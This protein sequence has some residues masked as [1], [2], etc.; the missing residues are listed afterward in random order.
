M[1]LGEINRLDIEDEPESKRFEGELIRGLELIEEMAGEEIGFLLI[2]V[3]EILMND[4]LF[5]EEVSLEGAHLEMK[6]EMSAIG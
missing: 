5:S 1:W 6:G 4:I 2:L 3:N